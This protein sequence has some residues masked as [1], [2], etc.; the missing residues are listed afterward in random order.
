MRN[1]GI[2]GFLAGGGGGGINLAVI[3]WEERTGIGGRGGYIDMKGDNRIMWVYGLRF[4]GNAWRTEWESV[5]L[6]WRRVGGV[7]MSRFST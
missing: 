1:L 5:S 2:E 7:D 3:E 4:V 6:C